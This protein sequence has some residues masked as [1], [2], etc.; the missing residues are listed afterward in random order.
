MFRDT[1]AF[2]Q[3]NIGDVA[4][5]GRGEKPSAAIVDSLMYGVAKRI[6][7]VAPDMPPQKAKDAVNKMLDNPKYQEAVSKRTSNPDNVKQRLDMSE[8]YLCQK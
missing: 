3:Q 6:T 7:K 8:Q 4:F 5:R 1:I 2:I